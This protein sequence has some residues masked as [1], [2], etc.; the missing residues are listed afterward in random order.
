MN[1]ITTALH[2]EGGY[3]RLKITCSNILG[4]LDDSYICSLSFLTQ[5]LVRISGVFVKLKA[6]RQSEAS[7]TQ[8]LVSSQMSSSIL[9]PS[10]SGLSGF[11][12]RSS[13]SFEI[14]DMCA[15]G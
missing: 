3:R 6:F 1:K 11:T 8:D 10:K 5:S 13:A 14:V 7:L 9:F 12:F 4:L 2:S 15:C